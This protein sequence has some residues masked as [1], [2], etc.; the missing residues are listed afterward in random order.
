MKQLTILLVASALLLTGCA[1]QPKPVVIPTTY[2]GQTAT[3]IAALIKGCTGIVAGDVGDGVKSGL[4]STASCTLNG[5]MIDINSWSENDNG[6]SATAVIKADKIEAYFA[7]G[8]G[9]VIATRDFPD[10]QLQFTNNA[11]TLLQHAFDGKTPPA[12]DLPGEK[13]TAQ[14]VVKAIGGEVIHVVP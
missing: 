4:A 8:N 1:S 13:A 11:G 14:L 6:E 12:A 7:A 10:L 3:A 5:R 9:W 2:P